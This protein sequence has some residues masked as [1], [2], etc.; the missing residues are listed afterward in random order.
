[1]SEVARE[2]PTALRSLRHNHLRREPAVTSAHGRVRA[3]VRRP[4]DPG[5]G[6]DRDVPAAAAA[7]PQHR[8][9]S[10]DG[11]AIARAVR[12]QAGL[13]LPG[14][15]V[16][17]VG[18]DGEQLPSGSDAM[19]HLLVRGPWVTDRYERDESPESFADGWFRTGDVAIRSA[20]GYYFVIADRT[21][22]LIKSGGEWISS[23][24][25][26]S[27]I[28]EIDGVIETAVIGIP[29]P[30]WDERPLPY[31]AT[32]VGRELTLHELHA[33]LTAAGFARWQLPSDFVSVD[34]IPKTAVGKADK[35][36]LRRIF[37]HDR[38][39]AGASPT[40]AGQ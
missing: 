11:D 23:V 14:V 29:D 19:G 27:A 17:V 38:A 21:K 3:R 28:C 22:D 15:D 16:R 7:W 8:M 9:R 13:P 25:M 40:A 18:D 35:K 1:M 24:A 26:E 20:D 2:N 33:T 31:I 36:L 34:E 4:D 10:W 6:D 39:D 12:N 32:T 37:V 30:R 5:V